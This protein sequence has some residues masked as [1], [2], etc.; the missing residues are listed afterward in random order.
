MTSNVLITQAHPMMKHLPS[1][2]RVQNH[3][4]LMVDIC[5]CCNQM[6]YY[7]NMVLLA[8]NIQWCP[9]ILDM[10]NS[11]AVLCSIH[12]T[13]ISVMTKLSQYNDRK[14]VNTGHTRTSDMTQLECMVSGT[15][16]IPNS[17]TEYE[18]LCEVYKPE[19]F[20]ITVNIRS[21]RSTNT[22]KHHYPLSK[23]QLRED[24]TLKWTLCRI[25]PSAKQLSL[26]LLNSTAGYY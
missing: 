8:G 18:Y 17:N 15:P 25:S 6:F 21:T 22:T 2:Y 26:G 4:I 10:S 12:A 14:N 7:G 1:T 24:I 3:L 16:S 20:V 11:V 19:C 5:L 13:Q 23:V 9:A